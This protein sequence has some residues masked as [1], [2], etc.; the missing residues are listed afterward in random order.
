M[1]GFRQR[2]VQKEG[3]WGGR[4]QGLCSTSVPIL[5]AYGLGQANPLMS[6]HG[7]PS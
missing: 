6:M 3:M 1:A 5:K 2:G 4:A 7:A